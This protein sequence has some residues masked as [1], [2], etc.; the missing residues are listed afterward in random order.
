MSDIREILMT[1]LDAKEFIEGLEAE[2]AELTAE[3]D[4]L[5]E[6]IDKWDETHNQK[7]AELEAERKQRIKDFDQFREMYHQQ[8]LKMQSVAEELFTPDSRTVIKH[9]NKWYVDLQKVRALSERLRGE[10]D[11]RKDWTD[12]QREE[13]FRRTEND[14][15]T[16]RE[17]E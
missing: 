7:I 9:K 14:F 11:K 5:R 6:M 16:K 13:W 12:E 17:P 1:D 4:S 10:P 15:S 8:N 3:R 2:I